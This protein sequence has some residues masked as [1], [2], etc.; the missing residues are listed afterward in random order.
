MSLKCCLGPLASGDHDL[1]LRDIGHIT[2]CVESGYLGLTPAIYLDLTKL[3][4]LGD[5]SDQF[6][7]RNKPDLDEDGSN[8][9][10]PLFTGF[11]VPDR[12]SFHPA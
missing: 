1:L 4:E 7:V 3:I 5:A 6:R 9:K 11:Q 2:S 10:F 8:L 12:D